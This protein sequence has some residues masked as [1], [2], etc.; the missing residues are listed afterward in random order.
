MI[1]YSLTRVI[2]SYTIPTIIYS[3]IRA[4]FFYTILREFRN[5]VLKK[6]DI[7]LVSR[8]ADRGGI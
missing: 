5:N 4:I 2:F 6:K 3:S 7:R 1:I 8:G